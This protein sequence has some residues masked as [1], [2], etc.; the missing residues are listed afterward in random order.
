MTRFH[1]IHNTQGLALLY[2]VQHHFL[3]IIYSYIND[4]LRLGHYCYSV[5]VGLYFNLTYLMELA[6]IFDLRTDGLK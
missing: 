1:T 4:L 6:R 2:I 3:Y 5:L